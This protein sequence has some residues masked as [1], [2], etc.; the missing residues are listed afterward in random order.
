MY[1][2]GN[3]DSDSAASELDNKLV[4]FPPPRS[5]ARRLDG[6]SAN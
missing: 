4:A 6:D 2:F 1:I 5:A 3:T